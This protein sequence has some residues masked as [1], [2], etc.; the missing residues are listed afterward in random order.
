MPEL[1]ATL[2]AL[3]RLKFPQR[4]VAALTLAVSRGA[5]LVAQVCVQIAVGALG[6][7]AALGLLQLLTSWTA[8]L[9]EVLGIGYPTRAMRDAAVLSA[10]GQ[11]RAVRRT[12]RKAASRVAAAGMGAAVLLCAAVAVSAGSTPDIDRPL[13]VALALAAPLCAL[14]RLWSEALKGLQRPLIAVTLENLTTPIALLTLCGALLLAQR[15]LSREL[16]LLGAVVGVAATAALSL[17]ALQRRLGQLHEDSALSQADGA[18]SQATPRTT[19]DRRE[20]LHFWCNG[21]LNI[22]FLQLPFLILPLF[23][24][25]EEIGRYAVAHLSLIH[26]SEP[27]RPAPLSRMPASA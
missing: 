17:V 11:S 25:A 13:I 18:A 21:L 10:S 7:P 16:L 12:L 1:A 8:L 19:T 9:G 3:A 2:P 5:G 6:G 15:H 24:S 23:A 14:S 20:Q 26:I 4:W 22:A 27:T